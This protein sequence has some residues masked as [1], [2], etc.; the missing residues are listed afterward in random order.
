PMPRPAPVMTTDL[1]LSIMARS[2][3]VPCAKRSRQYHS[4]ERGSVPSCPSRLERRDVGGAEDEHDASVVDEHHEG[5]EHTDRAVHLIAD[6]DSTDIEAKKLLRHLA[7]QRR[8]NGAGERRDLTR[9]A[10]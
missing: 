4:A 2:L 8:E 7:K 10:P 3:P 5:H 1:P 6:A 9:P